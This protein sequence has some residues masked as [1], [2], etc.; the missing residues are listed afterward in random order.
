MDNFDCGREPGFQSRC[1]NHPQPSAFLPPSHFHNGPA[2]PILLILNALEPR[3]QTTSQ[4]H[5]RPHAQ[6]SSIFCNSVTILC[7][8]GSN[9]RHKPHHPRPHA[10]NTSA[11]LYPAPSYILSPN[12]NSS[13]AATACR[14]RDP[15]TH[16]QRNR[17]K[18]TCLP[19][20]WLFVH[21]ELGHNLTP[22][23]GDT[24]LPQNG[25][26]KSGD[27]INPLTGLLK[28]PP[29]GIKP[30][31]GSK[32]AKKGVGGGFITTSITPVKCSFWP[33][34]RH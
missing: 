20:L 11:N 2:V 19:P 29:G 17:H 8:L 4:R 18:A 3:Y 30:P 6:I 27:K 23:K 28:R 31:Q 9:P 25:G 10:P 24:P 21:M 14:P 26:A 12:G 7:P 15:A 13:P 22:L 32:M 1:H 5:L 34:Q 16:M 33:V